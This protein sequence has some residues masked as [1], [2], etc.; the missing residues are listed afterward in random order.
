MNR[1]TGLGIVDN[2]ASI[3]VFRPFFVNVN[4]PYATYR[5]EVVDL[6]TTVF[7]YTK[8]EVE[9][10]VTLHNELN[11]FVLFPKDGKESDVDLNKQK[12]TIPANFGIPVH[13][14]VSPA[15]L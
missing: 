8:T 12:I 7:N 11:A 2:P 9:A 1:E 13:F 4:L 14:F 5:G 15:V 10:T 3:T 6:Q